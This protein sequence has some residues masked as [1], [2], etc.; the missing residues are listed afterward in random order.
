MGLKAQWDKVGGRILL[1]DN[2]GDGVVILW[3][4]MFQRSRVRIW[5][6]LSHNWPWVYSVLTCAKCYLYQ[7]FW[8]I[9]IAWSCGVSVPYTGISIYSNGLLIRSCT[10]IWTS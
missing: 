8:N 6:G 3:L 10:R 4:I 1:G 9:I 7:T 2:T 5:A